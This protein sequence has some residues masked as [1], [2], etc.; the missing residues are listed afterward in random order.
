MMHKNWKIEQIEFGYYSAT[1]LE[2]C[3]ED[4]IFSKS[5]DKLK[6]EIDEKL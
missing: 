2:D 4:L 1:N 3:D 5:I 6:I